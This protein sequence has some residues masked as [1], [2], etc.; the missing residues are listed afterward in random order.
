MPKNGYLIFVTK[1]GVTDYELE[2]RGCKRTRKKGRK[3]NKTD[4]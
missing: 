2:A 4:N 3:R 1:K